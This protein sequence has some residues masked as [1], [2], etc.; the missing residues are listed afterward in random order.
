MPKF[1]SG[2][3]LTGLEYPTANLKEGTVQVEET[4]SLMYSSVDTWENM[5]VTKG[6]IISIMLCLLVSIAIL[7]WSC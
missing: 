3:Y 1:I 5:G 7:G 2:K 4:P 6:R